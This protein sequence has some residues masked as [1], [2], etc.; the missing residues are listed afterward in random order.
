MLRPERKTKNE[1]AGFRPLNT[2]KPANLKR[3]GLAKTDSQS[4]AYAV[5]HGQLARSHS[6]QAGPAIIAFKIALLSSCGMFG[7][8]I[9]PT[10]EK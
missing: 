7:G 4:M 8:T 5:V 9:L 6:I 1:I 10:R 3:P 2:E